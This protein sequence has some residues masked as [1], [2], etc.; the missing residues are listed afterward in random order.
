MKIQSLVENTKYWKF[1]LMNFVNNLLFDQLIK[2]K[3]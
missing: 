2:A 3:R 1:N